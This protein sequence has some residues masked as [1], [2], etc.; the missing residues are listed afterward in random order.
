MELHQT[1]ASY[2]PESPTASS[3]L[4]GLNAQY[5]SHTASD[6]YLSE[7]AL[8][9]NHYRLLLANTAGHW[10]T[11]TFSLKGGM[12]EI[13]HL[14][15]NTMQSWLARVA[16]TVRNKAQVVM[17]R[18]YGA[19]HEQCHEAKG[20]VKEPIKLVRNMWNWDSLHKFNQSTL[21]TMLT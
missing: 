18:S 3:D 21:M 13:L 11:S 17:V 8:P 1:Y 9:A 20:P 19:G 4:F 7:F 6:A 14:F 16:E 2:D 10:T 5:D 15:E 12:G